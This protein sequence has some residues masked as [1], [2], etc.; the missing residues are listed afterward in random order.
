MK[1]LIDENLPKKLKADFKE[2]DIF[3]VRDKGWNS[4]KNG[5]L[6]ALMIENGFDVLMTFDQNLDISKI[7]PHS[8]SLL[9]F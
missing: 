4:K 2:H 3:T 6:L 7:F 1:I 8:Q 5:E 9:L